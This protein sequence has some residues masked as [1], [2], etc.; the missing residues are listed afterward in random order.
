MAVNQAEVE[1]S[2]WTAAQHAGHGMELRWYLPRS[3]S[4]G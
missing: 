2:V 1:A 3:V 4:D